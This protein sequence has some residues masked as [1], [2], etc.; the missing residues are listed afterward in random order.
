MLKPTLTS[1][2]I[3]AVISSATSAQE[4]MVWIINVP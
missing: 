2:A 4:A 3:A 1:L